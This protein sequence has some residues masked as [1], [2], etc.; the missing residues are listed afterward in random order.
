MVKEYSSRQ[1]ELI[2]LNEEGKYIKIPVLDSSLHVVP[3]RLAARLFDTDTFIIGPTPMKAHN[4]VVATLSV[5]NMVMGAPLRNA[6]KEAR[7]SDKSLYHAGP[8]IG[9]YNMLV[10]AQALLPYLG[11]AVIDGYEGMEG[12]GPH[13]GTPVPSRIAIASTDFIAA[14]RV[15][16]ECMS[17]DPR[18]VGYLQYCGQVGLGNYDLAKID[19]VGAAIASVQKKYRLHNDVDRQ[20]R[21]MQPGKVTVG[22]G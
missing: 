15:A 3:A 5:K 16:L 2:D 10:T 7:W 19:V 21:W 11:V 1:I 8:H 17:I 22:E 20:L 6:P 9:H 12:D 18:F 14:D 4:F 13:S